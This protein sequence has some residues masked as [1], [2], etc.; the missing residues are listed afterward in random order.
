MA[1]DLL[2]RSYLESEES[3]ELSRSFAEKR[4]PD[5]SKFGQ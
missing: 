5:A 3:H 2:L 1:H 4:A